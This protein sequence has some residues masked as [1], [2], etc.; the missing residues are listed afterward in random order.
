MIRV[1][2]SI[3]RGLRTSS[4]KDIAKLYDIG[5]DLQYKSYK[6][7]TLKHLEERIKIYTNEGFDYETIAVR[8]Q[9]E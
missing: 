3:G 9:G 2:Q 5:D 7:H 4:S 6:N 1:L 8:I